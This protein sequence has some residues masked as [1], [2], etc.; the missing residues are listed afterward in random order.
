VRQR[1]PQIRIVTRKYL[2]VCAEN[3]KDWCQQHDRQQLASGTAKTTCAPGLGVSGGHQLGLATLTKPA[4]TALL[5]LAPFI[6]VWEGLAT[7][8]FACLPH[9]LNDAALQALPEGRYME[10]LRWAI[11]EEV[12]HW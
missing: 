11:G 3:V 1:V 7:A 9:S 10:C 8:F 5:M 2:L 6:V 12:S 4:P